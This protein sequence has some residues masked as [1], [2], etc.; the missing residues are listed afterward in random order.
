MRNICDGMFKADVEFTD[1]ADFVLCAMGSHGDTELTDTEEG[2]TIIRV[3]Q[4]T[5]G[6]SEDNENGEDNEDGDDS[7]DKEKELRVKLKYEI[8]ERIYVKWMFYR[9]FLFDMSEK[10]STSIN[11]INSQRYVFSTKGFKGLI[12]IPMFNAGNPL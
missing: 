9:D 2:V 7:E 3:T 5:M 4:I 8:V 11:M 12:S 10:D 1:D 6:D